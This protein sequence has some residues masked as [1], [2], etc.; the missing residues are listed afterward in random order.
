MNKFSKIYKKSSDDILNF[1]KIASSEYFDLSLIGDFSD[2]EYS[3]FE[4][5]EYDREVLDI[6]GIGGS[7][8]NTVN[9]GTISSFILATLGIPVA[10]LSFPSYSGSV[11]SAD[12]L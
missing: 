2:A 10:K 12:V 5:F 3:L 7:I 1:I 11:G 8:Y 4:S 9:V 6:S